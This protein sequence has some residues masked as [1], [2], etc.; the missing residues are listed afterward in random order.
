MVCQCIMDPGIVDHPVG[1]EPLQGPIHRLQQLG[2][3]GGILSVTIGEG[4]RVD[5]APISHTELKLFPLPTIFRAMLLA[6]PLT[7]SADLQSGA[8]DD[9]GDGYSR[10]S[11]FWELDVERLVAPTECDRAGAGQGPKDE[12]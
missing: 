10:P 3:D 11:A 4:R 9:E 8:V 7:F 1:W 2:D 5:P 6:V 12:R